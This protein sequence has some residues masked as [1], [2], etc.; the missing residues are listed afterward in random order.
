MVAA[1]KQTYLF[2]DRSV[3]SYHVPEQTAGQAV[4]LILQ[5]SANNINC[6]LGNRG[7][8]VGQFRTQCFSIRWESITTDVAPLAVKDRPCLL[9]VL[10]LILQASLPCLKPLRWIFLVLV[11]FQWLY[12]LKVMQWHYRGFSSLV[13]VTKTPSSINTHPHCS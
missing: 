6:P 13:L 1:S 5:R 9:I 7:S 12:P 3:Q 2:L 10:S 8:P 11:A 4:L